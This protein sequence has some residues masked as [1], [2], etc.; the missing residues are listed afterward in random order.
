MSTVSSTPVTRVAETE[1]DV[2]RTAKRAARR[3]VRSIWLGRLGL[4]VI[5]FGGWQLC[6]SVNLVDPFFFGQPT[7][8]VKSLIDYFRNGTE[9]GS[10]YEQIWV[11]MQEALLGFVVGTLAGII[12]GVLLGQSRFLAE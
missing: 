2:A 9:F 3:S 1:Q 8:I 10:Y 11:T 12:L 5:I 4:A 6:T 7:G